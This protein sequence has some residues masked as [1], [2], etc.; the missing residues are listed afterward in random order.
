MS[1]QDTQALSPVTPARGGARLV[2]SILAVC[3]ALAL[4][5]FGAL[6]SS[7]NVIVD[8]GPALA[9]TG[10]SV[11][12]APAAIVAKAEPDVVRDVTVGGLTRLPDGAIRQ[13]YSTTP[14]SACPT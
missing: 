6:V 4:F 7:H 8:S 12:S 3:A 9:S 10:S 5:A 13:T 14:P 1:A 2:A 11:A